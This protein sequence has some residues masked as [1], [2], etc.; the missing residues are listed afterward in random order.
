MGCLFADVI[1]PDTWAI[2]ETREGETLAGGWATGYLVAGSK[3]AIMI[4]TGFGKENLREFAQTLTDR[5]VR[6]CALTHGHHDHAGGA[7]YFRAVFLTPK[8]EDVAAGFGSIPVSVQR[9]YITDGSKIDLG[10]RELEVFTLDG[11]S[12]GSVAFLD[13]RERLLFTG[14]NI[15]DRND[16]ANADGGMLWSI[17][18]TDWQPSLFLFVMKLAKLLRLRDQYDLVCWGHGDDKPLDA[19]I[20]EYFMLAA[21]LALDGAVDNQAD[22]E[23]NYDGTPKFQDLEYKR[24]SQVRNARILYDKRFMLARDGIK[25]SN[26]KLML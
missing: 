3:F 22:Q 2:R 4:D 20:V 26:T 8:A 18:S 12:P 13:R 7:K 19:D 9:L 15:G 1:A 11:H 21:L 25:H 10:G 23:I 24:V 16:A 14:D 17:K 6:M 5:P